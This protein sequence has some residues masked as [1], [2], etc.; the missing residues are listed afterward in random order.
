MVR[1]TLST[2]SSAPASISADVLVLGVRP[3]TDGAPATIA[4]PATT[5]F[6]ALALEVSK[7]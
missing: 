7:V 6:S 1:P 3:G 2:D 5:P 4:P